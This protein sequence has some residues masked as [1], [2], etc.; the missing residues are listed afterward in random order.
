MFTMLYFLGRAAEDFQTLGY[1]CAESDFFP[2]RHALRDI[3]AVRPRWG[4]AHI[5]P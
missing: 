3:A 2:E 5:L 4:V 1:V